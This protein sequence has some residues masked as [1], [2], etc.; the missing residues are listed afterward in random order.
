MKSYENKALFN[1]EYIIY[2][3]G[4]EDLVIKEKE[5]YSKFPKSFGEH[6]IIYNIIKN[7]LTNGSGTL[8]IKQF[9]IYSKWKRLL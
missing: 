8:K 6:L 1:S 3:F 4:G 9:E 5:V 2:A 7:E